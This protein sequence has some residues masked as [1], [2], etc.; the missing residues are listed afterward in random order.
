MQTLKTTTM[1]KRQKKVK[2]R[3]RWKDGNTST[4]GERAETTTI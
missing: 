4:K 2:R 1:Q 3:K